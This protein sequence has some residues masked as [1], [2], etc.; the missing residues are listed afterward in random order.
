LDVLSGCRD[1]EETDISSSFG[2]CFKRLFIFFRVDLFQSGIRKLLAL[3]HFEEAVDDED[4]FREIGGK[5][6]TKDI[7]LSLATDFLTEAPAPEHLFW[8]CSL[9][10]RD[11]PV[12][13][14]L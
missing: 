10:N 1:R 3:A 7:V 11:E 14:S 8:N 5:S 2:N 12:W 13:R 4:E 6:S 9:P